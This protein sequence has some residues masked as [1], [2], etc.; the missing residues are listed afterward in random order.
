MGYSSGVRRSTDAKTGLLPLTS[1]RRIP[2]LANGLE[3]NSA[4]VVNQASAKREH[5][6]LFL[7]SDDI[8][9]HRPRPKIAALAQAL[10]RRSRLWPGK[11]HS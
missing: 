6:L 9:A 4:L 11:I 5:A 3:K 2:N 1:R 10:K 7:L 8:A